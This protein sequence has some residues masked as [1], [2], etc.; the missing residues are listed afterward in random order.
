MGWTRVLR[1]GA[2]AAVMATAACGSSSGADSVGTHGSG[3]ATHSLAESSNGKTVT[4]RVG[5]HIV[6]ALHSTYWML[7]T[8]TGAVLTVTA[9]PRAGR[10]SGCPNIPG[11]GCGVV[12]ARYD[13]TSAGTTHLAA[14]RTTCGEAMRC[15]GN[16][17]AWSATVTAS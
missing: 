4:A 9:Q 15:T 17:G 14:S 2:V 1:V 3:G 11:T 8:P 7:A 5:D 13:V 6:V 16:Q 10:A 12:T